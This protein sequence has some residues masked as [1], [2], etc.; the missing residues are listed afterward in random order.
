MSRGETAAPLIGVTGPAR[1]GRTAWLFT[2][3]ALRLAGARVCRLSPAA[4][5]PSQPLAGLV[6]GGGD[7]IDPARY[8]EV[9]R[10]AIQLDRERD[11]LEW[12]M[13][14]R[15]TEAGLP[16]LGICRGAQLISVFYGGTLHQD[17]TELIAGWVLRRTV[18]PR[19]RIVIESGSRLRAIMATL[20]TRANS[21]HHQ[22]IKQLPGGFRVAA[23][24]TDGVIQAL[25]GINGRFCL[26]VQWHP[27]YLLQRRSQRRIF[28]ALVAAARRG[29]HWP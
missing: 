19:K 26:G 15:A 13:L 5:T 2:R 3:Q 4:P 11:A 20:E 17:L 8:G 22:A 29:G 24:D 9:P 18:L 10:V 12:Q 6:I 14:A 1:G 16:V 23:H 25:E 21:L 7:D 28:Q 27:E